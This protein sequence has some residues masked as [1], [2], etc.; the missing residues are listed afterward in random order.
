MYVRKYN[1]AVKHKPIVSD[2]KQYFLQ[3]IVHFIPL[4]S[5]KSVN[6]G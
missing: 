5:H 6:V 2:H 4:N 1:L 3:D